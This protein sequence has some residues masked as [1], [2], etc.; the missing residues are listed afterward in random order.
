MTGSRYDG[1]D[2]FR[3]LEQTICKDL[4]AALKGRGCIVTHNGTESRHAPGGM[5]DIEIHDSDN[6]RLILVEVTNRTGTKADGELAAMVSHLDA[7]INAGGYSEYG[8][9]FVSPKTSARMSS[10]LRD[11]V[12]RAREKGLFAFQVGVRV[13]SS[14]Q[15][16]LPA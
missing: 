7:K 8:M 14:V 11:M 6:S 3:E 15:S 9:L 1:L 4:S 10:H 5:A 16:G 13:W 12:N 2:A